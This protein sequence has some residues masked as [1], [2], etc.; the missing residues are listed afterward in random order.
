[1]DVFDT[2]DGSKP[3]LI[4]GKTLRDIESTLNIPDNIDDSNKVLNGIGNFYNEYVV[5]NLFP[6]IVISLFII[7][8]TIRYILKRD[9]EERD[10]KEEDKEK[11]RDRVKKHIIKVD[12]DDVTNKK[13]ETYNDNQ[14][15][16]S[17]IISDDYLLT[18]DDDDQE[19]DEDILRQVMERGSPYDI[20]KA[21]Q[22][23]F[24]QD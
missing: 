13:K 16:I 22:I 7:Y 17:D 14:I 18:D 5:P 24:N 21:T 12:L 19:N 1:M 9:R 6:L 3:N 15:D 11:K 10:E 4:S 8:L 2:F 20:E 23:I